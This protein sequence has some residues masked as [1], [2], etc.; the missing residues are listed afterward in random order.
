LSEPVSQQSDTELRSLVERALSVHYELD[1]EIGRGGMG[2]VYRAK[3]RRLKRTVAIKILPPELAFRSEIKTRFLREAEMAA[4]LNHPNIVDIYAVDE[5]GGIVF[6]VM[7][8]ITGDN[9][10]KLLH[11]HGALPIDQTRRIL[12]DVADALAYA[13]ERGVIHRD[14][15]PDNILIDADSGRPMVTDFGI[16]R[17]VSEGETRLTATGIAIGTPTYMSPEQA[18]GER[19]IDGRSDLY[20]LGILGYQMLTGEPPFVANSTPAIL[21]KHISERPT[22]IEQRRSD[23]PPDLARVIMQLLEK[24]PAN[25]FPSAGSVVVALDTGRLPAFSSSGGLTVAPATTA[26]SAPA[27]QTTGYPSSAPQALYAQKSPTPD[28][29]RRW[30][31]T[32]VVKF[33]KKVAPYLFINGVLVM[34]A[35][36][37]ATDQLW[38]TVIWT[39]FM[40][41]RYSRLWSDGYDWRDVFRQPRDRDLVDV[42]ED[43]IVYVRSMFDR[44]KRRALRE[45]RRN[46]L[47]RPANYPQPGGG[48]PQLPPLAMD[49][50]ARAAGNYGDRI[51]RAERDRNE[52]LALLERMP[53]SERQRIPDVGRSATALAERVRNLA[54]ALADIDRSA[55]AGGSEALE[56]EISTLE[57]AANP[58]D[59]AGSDGRVRRLAYLKRQRRAI[60]D[61]SAKRGSI[62]AKLDTCLVALQNIKLDLIRLNAGSQTPQHITSLA[63]D[64]LN[65][66]D[67]VDTALYVAD[68]MR[69]P[70]A[71][72]GSGGGAKQA[73]PSAAR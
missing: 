72:G 61:V 16:A 67:S 56:A 46:R 32:E 64:A 45:Q 31:A 8:Y 37:G 66:A 29:Y 2:V 3:D 27:A 63:M 62:A 14:I 26:P 55:A 10:A 59:E 22:P 4:Q 65:L 42:A 50:V 73:R 52:I 54:L 7:A 53:S 12:R 48:S 20:S 60:A 51:H 34:L 18:A 38:F 40:A 24:D 11:E 19:A 28:E 35:V 1:D 39:I 36:V 43:A 47:S 33:R 5:A 44:D 6:F 70:G 58:L 49:D 17:A 30:E 71:A 41:F 15:K 69:S 13:H 9:V 57:G 68:E 23:V 21:V 25:R